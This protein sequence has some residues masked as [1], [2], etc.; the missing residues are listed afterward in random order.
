MPTLEHEPEFHTM[1]WQHVYHLVYELPSGEDQEEIG[2]T[3]AFHMD[4]IGSNGVMLEKELH[5]LRW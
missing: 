3:I 1:R 4:L 2:S 5:H